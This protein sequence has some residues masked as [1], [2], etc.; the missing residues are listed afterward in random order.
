MFIRD[1]IVMIKGYSFFYIIYLAL[2]KI[3]TFLF[4]HG[5]KIIRFPFFLR[6]KKNI[7]IG[8]NCSFGF[9]CRLESYQ[10]G[11]ILI[12]DNV[13]INDYLHIGSA[14]SVRIKKDTLIA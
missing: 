6:G 14:I 7:S 3:F 2:C 4:F 1:G 11:N 5:V 12:E 13:L 8:K 10:G 9:G